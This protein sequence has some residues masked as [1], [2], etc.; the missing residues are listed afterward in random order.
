VSVHDSVKSYAKHFTESGDNIVSA[1][2]HLIKRVIKE[3]YAG[4]GYK[5]LMVNRI[6]RQHSL[7]NSLV[8]QFK[9]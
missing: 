2:H 9:L 4:D 6:F 1:R 7:M 8:N 3:L 5:L